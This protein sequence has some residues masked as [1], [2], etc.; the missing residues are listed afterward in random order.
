MKCVL[1]SALWWSPSG[2]WWCTAELFIL[3]SVDHQLLCSRALTVT[4]PWRIRN[5]LRKVRRWCHCEEMPMWSRCHVWKT[6]KMWITWKKKKK[7]SC[8]L[9][10]RNVMKA[11]PLRA[12]VPFHPHVSLCYYRSVYLIPTCVMWSRNEWDPCF[13]HAMLR[14]PPCT[15]CK[16]CAALF[17]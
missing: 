16:N 13:A 9:R 6:L 1:I 12:S 8:H 14:T 15:A 11:W 7:T 3:R 10:K 2:A 4:R 17:V 5:S